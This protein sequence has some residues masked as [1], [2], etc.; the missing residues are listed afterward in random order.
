MGKA[1]KA[2]K[3][4][5]ESKVEKVSAN[6]GRW[7]GILLV[8][9]LLVPLVAWW[10]SGSRSQAE[11]E[12]KRTEAAEGAVSAPEAS[13]SNVKAT[14][15]TKAST[16]KVSTKESPTKDASLQW[17]PKTIS[18]I[19]PCAGEGLFAQKTVVSVAESVPGGIGGGILQEIV[20]VDDGS[21]PPLSEEFL[22]TKFQK[23][24]P[25]KL[26]RHEVAVGLMGAKS[27][28]AGLAVGDVIVFF[29]CHVAPQ[30]D[31]YQKF[32]DGVAENYRRIVV[33][34]ITNL[35]ID[36]WKEM[37][38]NQGMAKCYLTWDADFKW[39]ESSEPYMPVLSGGLL[40]I[41][42]RWWNETGGYDEGMSGWGGEN[43]DQSLRSWLCGGEIV[44]LSNAF[45]AHMWRRREDPRTNQNYKV[46]QLDAIRNKAR[47]V[48]A[49]FD[50]YREK[51]AEYP[52]MA[53]VGLT[54]GES[55]VDLNRDVSNFE[56]VKKRLHCKPFAWFLWRFRDI[57]VEGG[58]LPD[59]IF[60]LREVKT[61]NC[62]TF[63]GPTGTHPQGR[64][65]ATLLPCD[66]PLTKFRGLHVEGQRW[67]ARNR[68]PSA[69]KCCS[70]IGSWNTDQC[71]LRPTSQETSTMGGSTVSTVV[72]DVSGKQVPPWN[73]QPDATGSLGKLVFGKYEGNNFAQA[74]CLVADKKRGQ[75]NIGPGGRSPLMAWSL[76]LANCK[77]STWEKMDIRVPM[78]TKLYQEALQQNAAL[79]K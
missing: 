49:W 60:K 17:A 71:L 75:F 45:V 39:V 65:S 74:K 35:D 48:L 42:R 25:V 26:V 57:Y 2:S 22:T 13:P 20:V 61:G 14:K 6:S 27:A 44:S 19:L 69:G 37:N 16:A 73:F 10:L 67:H 3:T 66:L 1:T 29:D 21:E 63:L 41:S 30:D 23:K 53:M 36:T 31:W 70:A 55:E 51:A 64:G 11:V 32:L 24:Y 58:L 46:S 34:V 12:G 50:E 15:T 7:R 18:V 52:A 56:E 28:G 72:C 59:K 76:K 79:F 38:R 78:E 9:S 8:V 40:G 4:K 54:S 62:L 77:H 5:V 33:P 68:D 47:A 43:V